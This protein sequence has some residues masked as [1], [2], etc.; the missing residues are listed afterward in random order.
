MCIDVESPRDMTWQGMEL[1]NGT[2]MFVSGSLLPRPFQRVAHVE[3]QLYAAAQAR[4]GA[5]SCC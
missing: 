3:C 1:G 4:K 5:I 2:L